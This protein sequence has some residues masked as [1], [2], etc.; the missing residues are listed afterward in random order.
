[1]GAFPFQL[2]RHTRC[3]KAHLGFSL[4]FLQLSPTWMQRA[5]W[6]STT[7]HLGISKETF[8][9]PPPD[10]R[11]WRS[12]TTTPSSTCE[13]CAE[14]GAGTSPPGSA[15]EFWALPQGCGHCS[16][17]GIRGSSWEIGVKKKF[18]Q[19]RRH[20]PSTTYLWLLEEIWGGLF[21][22]VFYILV[23][24]VF[25]LNWYVWIVSMGKLM[26]WPQKDGGT[27]S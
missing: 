20:V 16:P 13:P 12:C 3:S 18:W 6:V 26:H 24:R 9:S 27:V 23:L 1:M 22:C 19:R 17:W 25:L 11:A 4:F 15:G 5:N 10:H 2:H 8:S 7:G 21:T 14:V